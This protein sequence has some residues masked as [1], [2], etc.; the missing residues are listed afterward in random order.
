MGNKKNRNFS[1]KLGKENLLRF[2]NDNNKKLSEVM[3]NH[4]YELLKNKISKSKF[5]K[6]KIIKTN[7]SYDKIIKKNKYDLII[8]C[9]ANNIFI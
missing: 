6:E 7:F 5:F 8:N 1:E 9:D 3:T 4:I 2:E